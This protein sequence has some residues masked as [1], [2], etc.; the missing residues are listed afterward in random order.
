MQMGS[1]VLPATS[2]GPTIQSTKP[3]P[4]LF[5]SARKRSVILSLLLFLAVLAVY[6]PIV[7]N[8]F[9][10]VDDN[11]YV[12]ENPHVHQGLSPATLKWSLTTF[13]CENWHPLTWIS[14]ALDWELF[15]K[16]AAGHHYTSVLLH[17]INAVLLFLLLKSVTRFTW[18]SLAVAALFAV[19]PVNVE[20]V[21]W[22]AER[23]T[24]LSMLFFLLALWAYSW[25]AQRPSVKRYGSVAVLFAFGLMAKPQIITFPCVLLLWDYW[26][27]HRFGSGKRD[28]LPNRFAPASAGWLLLEKIPLLLL[29]AADALLTILA[30]RHA[31][32]EAMA[33]YSLPV[34]FANALVAY[35]RYV[36]H[37]VWPVRLSP[38][39]PY[40]GAIPTWQILAAGGFLLLV[41]VGALVSGRRYLLTGWLW[42]LGTLVP[43][44]GV[45]QV[46]DQAMADRYAYV[47]FLGLFFMVVW[48]VADLA[49]SWHISFRWLAVPAFVIILAVA[50][51]TPGQVRHWHDSE[52]L[53]RYALQVTDHNFIAH[54]YLAAV[55]TKEDR[56]E[57]AMEQYRASERLH[58]YPLTQVVYFADY[59]LRHG[60][61]SGAIADAN[62]V[63]Q[64]TNNPQARELAYRDRG[65][66]YTQL[67]KTA[68]ARENYNQALQLDPTDAYP[69]MGLGLLAYREKDFSSAAEYFKRAVAADPSAFDYLLLATALRQCGR[70]AEADAAYSQ[71]QRLSS[72]WTKTQGQVQYFLSN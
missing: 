39:Y 32:H 4:G 66:A 20:S 29:S 35:A 54:S 53:W 57:E 46:G 58:A 55:L 36:G 60:Q 72:D 59:E 50:S 37:A 21:A 52:S 49:G 43:M 3:E 30:Q 11:G 27:L 71:A 41:S 23:K 68:E 28:D 38:A 2:P 18:R 31:V 26:P 70:P 34:R 44:I 19:H 40:L 9:I 14:H 25:Y 69:I 10:N 17:G 13:A 16:N 8:A 65:S 12:T 51:L 45:I 61:V 22:V 33:Q 56:H 24:V 42:F 7:H 47:S 62:R 1:E 67:G 48:G 63:L 15:G 6:N 5:S 64:G